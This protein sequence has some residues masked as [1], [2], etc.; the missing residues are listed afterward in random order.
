[1]C[2]RARAPARLKNKTRFTMQHKIITIK[3]CDAPR[4]RGSRYLDHGS[5]QLQYYSLQTLGKVS[6][7]LNYQLPPSSLLYFITSFTSLS[8]EVDCDE[9]QCLQAWAWFAGWWRSPAAT[10]V[11]S[12][13]LPSR[14]CALSLSH[15]PPNPSPL[16]HANMC[17]ISS[18]IT[19]LLKPSTSSCYSTTVRYRTHSENSATQTTLTMS[20]LFLNHNSLFS[21]GVRKYYA[22]WYYI[23]STLAIIQDTVQSE[24]DRTETL[25]SH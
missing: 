16:R 24:D 21:N 4:P 1:M 19:Q 22:S 18:V 5:N 9:S 2:V 10:D 15:T 14:D 20:N 8:N 11:H 6:H 25:S 12:H 17:C 23:K 13:Y 7:S 3:L